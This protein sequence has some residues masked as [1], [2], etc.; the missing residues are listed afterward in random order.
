MAKIWIR[1]K[2][3]VDCKNYLVQKIAVIVRESPQNAL[4]SDLGLLDIFSNFPQIWLTLE[5]LQL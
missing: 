5:E 2:K 3:A 1:F 4:S